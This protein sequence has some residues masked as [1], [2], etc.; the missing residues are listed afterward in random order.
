[1]TLTDRSTHVAEYESG[2]QRTEVLIQEARQRQRK[3]HHVIAVALTGL[4]ALVASIVFAVSAGSNG[5]A[6]SVASPPQRSL[7]ASVAKGPVS[8]RPVLCLAPAYSPTA[9]TSS[10]T[11]PV[12]CAAQYRVGGV[13]PNPSVNGY[14]FN[15]ASADPALAADPTTSTAGIHQ[16]NSVLLG[17]L[18]VA[19]QSGQGQRYLLG[20]LQ[21]V[22]TPRSDVASASALRGP[23]GS[24][25][26]QIVFTN[27]G[28]RRWNVTA[29]SD[30]HQELAF[31]F[32]GKVVS[33]P[34][35]EP[36]Q[37][38]FTSFGNTSEITGGSLTISEA[39]QVAAALR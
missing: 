26:V 27:S 10:R 30:F 36:S 6:R 24:P 35:I 14:S 18:S 39:R 1:M 19:G 37:S 28:A 16:R 2:A 25:E 20:P 31:V 7:V 33:A 5:P 9:A 12:T 3:R 11:L 8:I 29:K 21:F 4:V 38:S 17:S 34:L 32:D 15:S 23:T 13:T 22:L